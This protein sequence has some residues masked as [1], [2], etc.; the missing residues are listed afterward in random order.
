MGTLLIS[1]WIPGRRDASGRVEAECGGSAIRLSLQRKREI[2]SLSLSLSLWTHPVDHA[3]SPDQGV[4]LDYSGFDEVSDELDLHGA[5]PL[6]GRR[7]LVIPLGRHRHGSS[8]QARHGVLPAFCVASADFERGWT[9]KSRF[10]QIRGVYILVSDI[11]KVGLGSFILSP[12][13]N[14]VRPLVYS[15]KKA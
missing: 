4:V 11:Q 10:T 8:T 9:R 15:L 2:L 1:S 6:L 14:K 7:V 12:K 5:R 13:P 3:L